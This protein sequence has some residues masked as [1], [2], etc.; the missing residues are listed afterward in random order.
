VRSSSDTT[1]ARRPD[2]MPGPCSRRHAQQLVGEVVAVREPDA[3]LAERF[4]VVRGRR[5]AGRGPRCRARRGLPADARTPHRGT[6][7][8]RG[9]PRVERDVALVADHLIGGDAGAAVIARE[10]LEAPRVGLRARAPAAPAPPAGCRARA[11]PGS[12]PTGRS[13][14]ARRPAPRAGGRAPR[15]R[16]PWC[17]LPR[18][19]HAARLRAPARVSSYT[20]KWLAS[21]ALPRST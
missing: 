14:A 19:L 20:S 4:A 18:A 11:D 17:R 2:A 6:R 1:A 12:A 8:R 3:V 10:H 13:A 16:R 15:A 21:S 5:R 7:P 9:S